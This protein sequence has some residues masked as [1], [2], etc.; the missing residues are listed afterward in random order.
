MGLGVVGAL[1][2]ANHRWG[3]SPACAAEITGA[4]KIT[5]HLNLLPVTSV[6]QEW[7]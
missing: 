1:F 5:G 4:E 7:R 6:T 3:L 2:V